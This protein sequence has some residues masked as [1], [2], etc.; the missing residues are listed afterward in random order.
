[1]T[2]S[3]LKSSISSNVLTKKNETQLEPP[4]DDSLK[5]FFKQKTTDITLPLVQYFDDQQAVRT[6]DTYKLSTIQ[7]ETLVGLMLGDGHLVPSTAKHNRNNPATYRL[8]LLQSDAH[9]DYLF[10]LY[11]IFKGLT[12]TG[13]RYYEFLDNRNPGKVYK[14]WSFSTILQPCLRFYGQQFYQYDKINDLYCR[15]VPKNIGRFLEA[16]SLAYWYMDDGAAKWHG[17]SL[18]LR[19]CTDSFTLSEVHCLM[20]CLKTK[21]G[22][23]CSA[24][25]KG[26]IYR[27]YVKQNSYYKI[28]NLMFSYLVPS[29]VHKFPKEYEILKKD[30]RSL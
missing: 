12:R 18:A 25:K 30:S 17:R 20:V 13:P 28:R 4:L 7:R 22:L 6:A 5:D 10:H 2:D 19:Y 24:Q 9:K 8:V 1:M 15:K 29:M 21:F 3:L 27:I 26:K 14:R 16:R 11:E 23:D